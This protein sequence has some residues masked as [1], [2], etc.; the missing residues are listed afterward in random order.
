MADPRFDYWDECVAIAFEEAG[1]TATKEQREYVAGAV[2]SSHE[3]YEQAFYSPP[4]SDRIA[5]IEREYRRKLDAKDAEMLAQEK[6][7]TERSE[8]LLRANNRLRWRIE[9]LQEQSRG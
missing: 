2:E 6:A 4:A 8:D 9:E 1:I 3:H 5:D 7:A